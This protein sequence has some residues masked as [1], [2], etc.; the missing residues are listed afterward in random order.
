MNI[1]FSRK[2]VMESHEICHTEAILMSTVFIMT[3]GTPYQ[4]IYKSISF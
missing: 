2:H 3:I 1:Y 4:Y